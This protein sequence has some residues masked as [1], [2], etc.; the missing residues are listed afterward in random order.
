MADH[1]QSKQQEKATSKP[2]QSP[3]P[4][5]DIPLLLNLSLTISQLIIVVLGAITTILSLLVGAPVWIAA[6]RGGVAILCVGLFM[7]LANWFLAQRTF[8]AVIE[9][10]EEKQHNAH[11][12]STIEKSA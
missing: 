8:E 5:T 3:R 6:L 2:E 12:N 1:D 10:L 9:E 7:I 11:A 4:A